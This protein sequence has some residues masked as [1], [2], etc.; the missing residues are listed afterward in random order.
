MLLNKRR[1]TDG[2]YTVHLRLHPCASSAGCNCYR[3][4][5]QNIE[6]H[7]RNIKNKRG[8][9]K[10]PAEKPGKEKLNFY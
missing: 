9:E 7:S 10:G 3:L 8:T 6:K 2:K 4:H 5:C 1:F